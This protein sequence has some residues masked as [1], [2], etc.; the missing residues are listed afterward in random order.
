MASKLSNFV[1]HN[2][3]DPRTAQKTVAEFEE[4]IRGWFGARFA[5]FVSSGTAAIHC[6]LASLDIATGDEVLIP[7][8]AVAMSVAPVLYLG[9]TPVFVDI[10]EGRVDF[11]YDDLA[12]KVSSRTKAIL[13][14][15]MWGCSYEMPKLM[16]FAEAHK[17]SV[18]EDACQAHGSRYGGQFLGTFGR[19][20]CFSTHGSK[21]LST[22]EG[23]FVLTDDPHLDKFLKLFR[24]HWQSDSEPNSSFAR[25]AFNY[26][27]TGMQAHAGKAQ[28]AAL[29]TRLATM[30]D[31][32]AV[33][34]SRLHRT[35][36][37]AVYQYLPREIPNHS[38]I[39]LLYRGDGR[40]VAR[41]LA[42]Q[43]IANSVGSY[44]LAPVHIRPFLQNDRTLRTS[45]QVSPNALS[46]INRI[47]AIPI[48]DY[49]DTVTLDNL[50]ESLNA[51]L[52]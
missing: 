30:R 22:G 29:Q 11:D 21:L 14:V 24:N 3:L 10:A 40:V 15:Y 5:T 13:P 45:D 28:L 16:K 20:G 50:I 1:G 34:I 25:L 42:E 51:C 26:R 36:N 32:A 18:V 27:A 2:L 33:I 35:G 7:T 4:E 43:G 17:L 9:A 31:R 48:M 12:K 37:F 19:L 23:G 52:A 8:L 44:G 41:K 38:N 6:A 47:L 39:L 49:N 46:L